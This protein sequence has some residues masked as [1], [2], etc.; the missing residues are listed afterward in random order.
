MYLPVVK[1]P[2]FVPVIPRLLK[3][4]GLW[5]EED[6]SLCMILQFLCD[7][8]VVVDSIDSRSVLPQEKTTSQEEAER[9]LLLLKRK[10]WLP[11]ASSN[12]DAIVLDLCVNG[13]DF[14]QDVWVIN[15]EVSTDPA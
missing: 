15:G 11:E 6:V 2:V 7:L 5:L 14:F 13:L 10:E 12:V 8:P 9:N 4:V 1:K 3:T